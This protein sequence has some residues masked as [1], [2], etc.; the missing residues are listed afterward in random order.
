M[1]KLMRINTTD[2]F[3]WTV[4]DAHIYD[5][6]KEGLNELF[7]REPVNC[8]PKIKFKRKVDRIDDF[9]FDDIEII[10]YSH[11][12]KILFPVAA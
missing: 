4:G 11:R 5:N 9:V 7:K 10:D 1:V 12:E 2:E 8:I 6:Q 3:T